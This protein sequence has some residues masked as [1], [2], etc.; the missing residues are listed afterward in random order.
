MSWAWEWH[1]VATAVITARCHYRCDTR[2]GGKDQRTPN[3]VE[4]YT[5]V[6]CYDRAH[7]GSIDTALLLTTG[8]D[9]LQLFVLIV[10][11]TNTMVR[12]VPTVW[13]KLTHP[14][15]RFSKLGFWTTGRA[16]WIRQERCL[17]ATFIYIYIYIY[18]YIFS[19]K[20]FQSHHFR[21]VHPPC[22]GGNGVWNSSQRVCYLAFYLVHGYYKYCC[23]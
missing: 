23:V 18:I 17:F 11:I 6:S 7:L 5:I 1:V 20:S 8:A 22:F 19:T 21:C 9:V 14:L 15:G 12:V 2:P 3:I 16:Y 10:S 13:R 4:Q